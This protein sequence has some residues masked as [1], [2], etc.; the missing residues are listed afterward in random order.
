MTKFFSI[1][2]LV[3]HKLKPKYYILENQLSGIGSIVGKQ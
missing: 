1:Q 2:K 3:T